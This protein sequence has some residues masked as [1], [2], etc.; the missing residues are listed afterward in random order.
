MRHFFAALNQLSA[1]M[2][3]ALEHILT[4]LEPTIAQLRQQLTALLCFVAHSFAQLARL[5]PQLVGRVAQVLR[6]LSNILAAIARQLFQSLAKVGL[7][8]LRDLWQGLRRRHY[9][10]RPSTRSPLYPRAN[11]RADQG[12]GEYGG[13][14]PLA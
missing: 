12:I 2:F 5:R 13:A 8:A 1:Q 10:L 9:G 6:L 14:Q 4:P 7:A 11:G 3:A